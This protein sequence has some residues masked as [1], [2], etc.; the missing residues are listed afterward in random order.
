MATTSFDLSTFNSIFPA[1]KVLPLVYDD[2]LSYYECLLKLQAK[3]NELIAYA[4]SLDTNAQQYTDAQIAILKATLQ[5]EIATNVTQLQASI[6]ALATKQAGDVSTLSSEIDALIAD[7][8]AVVSS[9]DDKINAAIA[10]Y[11]VYIKNYIASQL[12]DVK[13]VNFFTGQTV[14][15]QQMFDYLAQ[16]HVVNGLTYNQLATRGYTYDEI[17]AACA[18]GNYTYTDLIKDAATILP[19]K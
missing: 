16:L 17:I 1:Y 9:L 3:V 2:S 11:D 14:T 7:I 10:L 8:N 13:V 6:D 18:A 4:E 19:Q 5:A 15:I 12:I